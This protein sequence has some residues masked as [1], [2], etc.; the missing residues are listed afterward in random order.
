M[1]VCAFI[2]DEVSAAGFRL[3]GMDVHVPADDPT[4]DPAGAQ[5]GDQAV[6][7]FRQ[8]LRDRQLVLLT[9]EFADRLPP[10]LLDAALRAERPLVLVI[11]DIRGGSAPA[12]LASRLRRQ[13]G[14]SE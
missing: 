8:I 13:L 12:D 7:L 9:A 14:M 1:A 4:G 3:A 10:D 2:G 11:P 5:A 6:D